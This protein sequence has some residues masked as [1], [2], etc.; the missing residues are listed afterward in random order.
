MRS[1]MIISMTEAQPASSRASKRRCVYSAAT[2]F[3]ATTGI[4]A[5]TAV[6]LD[7]ATG[8]GGTS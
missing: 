7:P 3:D 4:H 6:N 5:A 1:E 2:W 8:P